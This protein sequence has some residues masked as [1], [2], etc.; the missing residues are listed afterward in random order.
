LSVINSTPAWSKRELKR[1]GEALAA[2]NATPEQHDQYNEVMLW[3]NDLAAAVAT[4]LYTT[5]WESCSSDVFDITARPKTIDTLVQKL[6]REN[7]L[8]LDQVQDLA[9]V[10]IDADITLD[11]Q[12]AL[13]AEIA[14]HFGDQSRVRD[15]RE[16]PH[17]GYR[18]V[19]VW[20]RLPSGRVEVQLRTV[21]QSEWA[22]TYERLGDR[23]GRG[24]RYDQTPESAP[25]QALVSAMHKMSGALANSEEAKV[26][27][28]AVAE[29]LELQY[30]QV[31]GMPR[32]AKWRYPMRY[33]KMQRALKTAVRR[34]DETKAVLDKNE[35]IY[36]EML[37]DTRSTLDKEGS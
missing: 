28:T 37:R 19:H 24:V 11:V 30:Q 35:K 4:V 2:G 8:T 12:T 9:G 17:S 13:A 5:E 32:R 3:H 36:L 16:N 27:L 1:L 34:F 20:L 22:N 33:R 26:T 7:N 29:D 18:A 23:F 15:L 21:P 6:Q 14:A 25:V 10:R 31:T